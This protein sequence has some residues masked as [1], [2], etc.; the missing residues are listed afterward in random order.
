MARDIEPR[1]PVKQDKVLAD[2]RKCGMACKYVQMVITTF[3]VKHK[4]P[5]ILLEQLQSC[6][7]TL[8]FKLTGSQRIINIMQIQN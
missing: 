7:D 3:I 2:T 6:W 4:H 5:A 8:I 1:K